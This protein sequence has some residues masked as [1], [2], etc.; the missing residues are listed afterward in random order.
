MFIPNK[1]LINQEL[2][3]RKFFKQNDYIEYDMI[4]KQLLIQKPKDFLKHL[5]KENCIFLE[6]CCYNKESLKNLQEHIDTLIKIEGFI[7]LQH[8]FPTLLN[9]DDIEI[10]VNKYMG[11]TSQKCEL[12]ET[13]LFSYEYLEKCCSK[14]KEKIVAFIYQAPQKLV[15]NEKQPVGNKKGKKNKSGNNSNKEQNIFS[16]EEVIKVIFFFNRI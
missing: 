4:S 5:F 3:A 9:L 10:L 13:I 16:K 7:D 11:L 6:T 12:I 1:F 15:E 2:I 8:N 14:F